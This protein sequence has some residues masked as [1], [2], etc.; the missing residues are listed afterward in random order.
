METGVEMSESSTDR[1]EKRIELNA[2]P[3]RIWRALTDHREFGTWFGVSLE[4]PFVPGKSTRGRITHPGYE[5]L[6]MEVVVEKMETERLFSFHWHPYAVNPNVDYSKE[7]PTLVEFR[8]EMTADGTRLTVTESGFD[9]IPMVRRD[10]AYRMNSGGWTEQL[11]N[12]N[13]H[14]AG[15]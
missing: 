15:A 4:A 12:L 8:L 3:T 13:A 6:S 14:L 7:S 5:H 11:K 9:L 10:E 1:I 2:S